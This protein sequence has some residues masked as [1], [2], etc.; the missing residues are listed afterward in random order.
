MFQVDVFLP[1]MNMR[2]HFYIFSALGGFHCDSFLFHGS[3]P[4]QPLPTKAPPRR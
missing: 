2:Q 4:G 3:A 1:E